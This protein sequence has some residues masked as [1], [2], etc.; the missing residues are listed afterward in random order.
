MIG[1]DP[2]DIV[3]LSL[4]DNHHMMIVIPM[5][6][7]VF[8]IHSTGTSPLMWTGLTAA[9]VGGRT[10]VT[11]A[12]L[13]YEPNP[14]VERPQKVLV[15]DEVTHVLSQLPEGDAPIHL[16]AHSYGGLVALHMLPKIRHRLASIFFLEPVTFGTLAVDALSPP[17][18]VASAKEFEQNPQFLHDDAFGG[19]EAWLESFID[20]WNRPGSWGRMP[21]PL[22]EWTRSVS[23]KMFQEVRAC[24]HENAPFES[25]EFIVP[26]TMAVGERT[27]VASRAMS[28]GLARGRKNVEMVE[29]AGTGHMAPLTHPQKVAAELAAHFAKLGKP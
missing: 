6:E 25:W 10:I 13:G 15:T 26:T 22:K 9:E 4:Y 19:T 7:I 5:D 11:P 18:A 2:C 27:T 21:E 23:W 29:M 17:E 16:V 20:Y 3:G 24:F 14:K 1:A 8:C 12:N 28:R